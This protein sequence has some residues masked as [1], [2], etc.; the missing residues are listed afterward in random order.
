MENLGMATALVIATLI[1]H[2]SIPFL[3]FLAAWLL[4]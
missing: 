1:P 4:P 2:V 3:T